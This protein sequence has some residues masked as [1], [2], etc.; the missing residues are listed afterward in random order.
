[1]TNYKLSAK[2]MIRRFE[3]LQTSVDRDGS[4]A[5]HLYRQSFV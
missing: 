3:L 1:M 5:K 2:S 4:K